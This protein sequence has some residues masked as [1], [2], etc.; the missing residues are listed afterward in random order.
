M[1]DHALSE[2]A[3]EWLIAAGHA[4]LAH[5]AGPEAR[6]EQMQD[7][8]LDA[9]D[10]LIDRH[11]V[12]VFLAVERRRLEPWRGEAIEVPA[13]INEGVERVGFPPSR[14]AAGRA[15]DVL[16]GRMAVERVA[17]LVDV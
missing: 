3:V 2:Q 8:V 6:I 17:R 12:V 5:G 9:A 16:P 13:R 14:P 4:D 11:P 15:G 10:I 1:Q 7:R